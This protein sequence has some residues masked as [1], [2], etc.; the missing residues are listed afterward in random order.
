MRINIRYPWW[1][2]PTVVLVCAIITN[3]ILTQVFKK[4]AADKEGKSASTEVTRTD[5]GRAG[6][7]SG[8]LDFTDDTLEQRLIGMGLADIQAIDS[9]ILVDLRY[10]TSDN[11][12]KESVYG[13]LTKCYLRPF[14]AEMLSR[15]QDILSARKPGYRLL[16]YDG[17]RPLSV[18]RK[19]WNI[20]RESGNED[21]VA[22][23][24]KG[25]LHNL[26][27]AV[28][29]TIA[30]AKGMPLD[31]GSPYDHFG[32][33]SQPRYEKELISSGELSYEQFE[34]RWLLRSIMREAGFSII[35]TEWWHFNAEDKATART[36]YALIP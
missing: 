3:S 12:L 34:N 19:M 35:L 11:F 26:G 22:N 31:M 25:S 33:I 15:A 6:Q 17:A 20:A 30:D 4:K 29:L 10:A 14:A 28:D 23:P 2:I 18:Q 8:S 5:T 24:E 36:K 21:Y 32:M 9:N 13:N 1:L 16:V 27:V 7:G